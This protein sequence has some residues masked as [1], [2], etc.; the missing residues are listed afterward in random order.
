MWTKFS[1]ILTPSP[2]DWANMDILHT[3]YPLSRDPPPPSSCPQSYWMT[4]YV[5]RENIIR[6]VYFNENEWICKV[7][8]LQMSKM[9]WKLQFNLHS[10]FSHFIIIMNV[11]EAIFLL[12]QLTNLFQ[13]TIEVPIFGR[14]FSFF[15]FTLKRYKIHFFFK[16]AKK[17]GDSKP[18]LSDGNTYDW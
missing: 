4:P 5:S 8:E 7:L 9:T 6:K 10:F 17:K 15:N 13:M 12:S 11:P 2:L 18:I 1:P 16:V 3:I 14:R